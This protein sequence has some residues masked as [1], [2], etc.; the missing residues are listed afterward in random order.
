MSKWSDE[1]IASY[2]TV[3]VVKAIT[4]SIKKTIKE[5]NERQKRIYGKTKTSY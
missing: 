4:E 1:F 5:E 3:G 2:K